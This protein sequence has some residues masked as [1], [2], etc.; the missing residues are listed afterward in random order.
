M[1][2]AVKSG[3]REELFKEDL[4]GISNTDILSLV[5]GLELANQRFLY[6][7][8]GNSTIEHIW[9]Y[10]LVGL[11][12]SLETPFD[13]ERLE[14][15]IR[16]LRQKQ[17]V[18]EQ[19]R[20]IFGFDG[21]RGVRNAEDFFFFLTYLCESEK[22]RSATDPID[23]AL[24]M[25]HRSLKNKFTFYETARRAALHTEDLMALAGKRLAGPGFTLF[26]ESETSPIT[27][28][29]VREGSEAWSLISPEDILS[30]IDGEELLDR[31]LE[32]AIDLLRGPYGSYVK[33]EIIRKQGGEEITF[34]FKLT[35]TTG[36]PEIVSTEQ[37]DDITFLVKIYTLDSER[38]E[39]EVKE[40]LAQIRSTYRSPDIILDL[41]DNRGGLL[42][43]A[44]GV[45]EEFIPKGVIV[46][47]LDK[48][49]KLE[50]FY[51]ESKEENMGFG[52][53]VVLVNKNTA[54]AAEIITAALKSY[55]A[56]VVGERTYGKGVGQ[57]RHPLPN[58]GLST[59]T[60]FWLLTP[61]FES[62][63]EVGIEP[64]FKIDCFSAAEMVSFSVSAKNLPQHLRQDQFVQIGY[65][66]LEELEMPDSQDLCS[67]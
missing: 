14:A 30:K 59:V 4:Y 34:E 58:G 53:V 38:A 56:A 43:A 10:A 17:E 13:R 52:N 61:D 48:S 57:L 47:T 55:G 23:R 54:S 39:R 36:L 16:Y 21:I 46:H 32:E 44:V 20:G 41:R 64:N 3:S 65:G 45:A 2:E 62:F 11:N 28:I 12:S 42:T 63:H 33:V 25:A 50:S 35:R 31:T 9:W 37:L 15:T 22:I 7:V 27:I 67:A 66:L 6:D 18:A 26:R 5:T 1:A 49:E 51:S 29:N 8:G 19:F 24:E 40:A 60:S